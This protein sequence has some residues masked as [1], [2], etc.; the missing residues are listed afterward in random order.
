MNDFI[1][2]LVQ[3]GSIFIGTEDILSEKVNVVDLRRKVGMVFQSPNP[4]PKS[5][6]KNILWAPKV[7]GLEFDADELL[8]RSLKKAALW[9]EVK[10]RLHSSALTFVWGVNSKGY[11]LQELLL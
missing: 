7:N 5:I 11:V 6:M 1:E 8:E 4:F 9:D 2:N 10:D 3:S